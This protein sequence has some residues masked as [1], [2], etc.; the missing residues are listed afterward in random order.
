[1]T[2]KFE[3]LIQQLQLRLARATTSMLRLRNEALREHL[4]L[5][6]EQ[7]F[8]STDSLTGDAVFEST[9]GW[10]EQS[11]TMQQL[12]GSLLHPAVVAAMDDASCNEQRFPRTRTPYAHQLEAW[13]TLCGK[14][15][16][17]VVVKSGTGSG[18]TECFLVPVLDDLMREADAA[19]RLTGVR[20]LFLYPL[21]A[22][23]NSQ[24]ERLEAWCNPLEGKVRFALYNGNTPQSVKKAERDSHVAE[25]VD[26][27]TLREDPPPIVVTNSTMLEYV[28]VRREDAP[29]RDA[30][31]GKLRWIVIDEAHSYVGSAA[32]E[33]ALLLRRVAH[34][35]DVGPEDI[36]YVATSATIGGAESDGALR[37]FL[38]EVAGVPEDRVVVVTG[39][40]TKPS[41]VAPKAP[42]TADI[43]ALQEADPATIAAAVSQDPAITA[44]RAALSTHRTSG[45][46]LDSLVRIYTGQASKSAND[47]ARTLR[48]LDIASE[49]EVVRP[50]GTTEPFLP[51]RGHLFARPLVGVWACWNPKCPERPSEAGQSWPFGRI[52]LEHRTNCG[53]CK[54]QASEV[55]SCSECGEVYLSAVEDHDKG[56]R[57]RGHYV[58]EDD[59][60]DLDLEPV[61]D[62]S[63][64]TEE[65]DDKSSAGKSES[66]YLLTTRPVDPYALKA[67]LALPIR[68]SAGDG[69]FAPDNGG[70]I[71]LVRSLD[72]HQ[73][74]NQK[75]RF[76]CILCL[77][78][79]TT[80]R[81]MLRGLRSG[82]PFSLSVA[83]P[84]LLEACPPMEGKQRNAPSDG[85]RLITFTDS[86]QGTARFAARSQAE[87]E[88]NYVR[89]KLL[90]HLVEARIKAGPDA[91]ELEV[92]R[93][94][95]DRLAGKLGAGDEDV[96]ELD[97]EI[98]EKSR[99][100]PGRLTW[101]EL[102]DR[103][104]ADRE[105]SH[106]V[107]R[108]WE[109]ISLGN[110]SKDRVP[111]ILLFREFM[112]R[113][114][115]MTSL[116][117]LGFARI[118]YPWI[119]ACDA[120]SEWPRSASKEDWQDLVKL[121]IDYLFRS[122][123]A[124]V[125][126]QDCVRWLGTKIRLRS[127]QGPDAS[128]N[129]STD[130]I[131]WPSVKKSG[132]SNLPRF[133]KLMARGLGLSLDK[134]EDVHTVNVLLHRLWTT[135][136]P[137][138]TAD[139]AEEYRYDFATKGNFELESVH[140]A[141]LCPITR[142]VLDTTFRGLTPYMPRV[143]APDEFCKATKFRM[144]QVP[145]AFWDAVE[146]GKWSSRAVND[147]LESDADVLE[148]RR[149]GA[150]V[151]ASD[152]IAATTDYFRVGEHSAQQGSSRL[153][154]LEK[155]FKGGWL[156]VLSCSTT[157][158]M[159]VDIGGLSTVAMNN[160]PP[161]PANYLQRAGRAGR[162]KEKRAAAFTLCS[163]SPHGASVFRSPE[164][165]FTTVIEPPKLALDSVP[166]AERHV[167]ALLLSEFLA[168]TT[169]NATGKTC[170]WFFEPDT[171]GAAQC[172]RFADWCR[173]VTA[174]QHPRVARGLARLVVGTSLEGRDTTALALR[175]V[176]NL[177]AV[178]A[179]WR[180]E[181][182]S[183]LAQ[184]KSVAKAKPS[185]EDDVQVPDSQGRRKPKGNPAEVAIHH[186]LE[187]I[188]GEYL[189]REL[190]E[191]GFLPGYGFPT[192]LGEF[193]YTTA[194]D[195]SADEYRR[196]KQKADTEAA[197]EEGFDR[198]G[199]ARKREYPSRPLPLAIRDY[200]PG[201]RV[202]LDGRVYQ[203]HGIS[204][205]WHVPA[206]EASVQELQELR[207][208]VHCKQC[209]T[210]RTE[211][212]KPESCSNCGSTTIRAHQYL[213]PAGFATDIR[214][215]PDNDI[216]NVHY[217]PVSDPWVSVPD[218]EWASLDNPGLGAHRSSRHGI[219]FHF[220]AGSA[221]FG[222]AICL[223]CGR[224]AEETEEKEKALPKA[225]IDHRPLRG[226][227]ED[228]T[229]C[230]ANDEQWAFQ[231]NIWLGVSSQTDVYEVSWNDPRT[232]QPWTDEAGLETLA[233]AMREGLANVLGIE[234]REL[235]VVVHDL[236]RPGGNEERP[237]IAIY[238]TAP[239]GAGYASI[240]G[241]RLREVLANAKSVLECKER[242]AS[243]CHACVLTYDTQG[244]ADRLNRHAALEFLQLVEAGGYSMPPEHQFFGNG[245]TAEV[246]PLRHVLQ[247]ATK[248]HSPELVRIHLTGDAKKWDL[249]REAWRMAA[250]LTTLAAAGCRVEL[251][252]T[253]RALT[254][255]DAAV[256]SRLASNC[257]SSGW[258][259]FAVAESVRAGKGFLLAELVVD[260]RL[261]QWAT[262]SEATGAPGPEW[263]SAR[264][265]SVLVRGESSGKAATAGRLVSVAELRPAP[266][267]GLRDAGIRTELD[268]SVQEFGSK[269]WNHMIRVS[270]EL[271]SRLQ[272]ANSPLVTVRYTDRYLRSPL[273]VRLLHCVLRR[274][275]ELTPRSGAAT[276]PRAEV[277]TTYP[278]RMRERI[279]Q[280]V[281]EDDWDESD[282]QRNLIE[283]MLRDAGFEPKLTRQA[284]SQ[285]PHAR[286]LELTWQDGAR[287]VIALD[288]GMGAWKT[289][290]D[291]SYAF[292]DDLARQASRM[293]GAKFDVCNRSTH[294][295][296]V[297]VHLASPP[298][299]K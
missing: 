244:R 57:L 94:K 213:E 141:W 42:R 75:A 252:V 260:N 121:S 222:Y 294:T 219:V 24:R 18:K 203:S 280:A 115:R 4:R 28:L 199:P 97:R 230:K 239:G 258:Q 212:H 33:L 90:H 72:G 29:I 267:P 1:M 80:R 147:W 91:K 266:R 221:R 277:L 240:A 30:S 111:G 11:L 106:W 96:R 264:A 247:R 246:S 133:V 19:G 298:T 206:S 179:K 241:S 205:H 184:Q 43:D 187:R 256:R 3:P 149:I 53:T 228:G 20:A 44:V 265:Q 112:R 34:A 117:T 137:H 275:A 161:H 165:P 176:G 245:S 250:E 220:Q 223:R 156:N 214:E 145:H 170:T 278:S 131:K 36:R 297:Y 215:E 105:I 270:P 195:L 55:L 135:V 174:A 153:Q 41:Q 290:S 50:D 138:L 10:E 263:G 268:C 226:R 95:R 32:A 167:H 202:V 257:E 173:D 108:D 40:R 87:S 269:F 271:V 171:T 194:Y 152:R 251:V 276:G 234:T 166:I 88:R 52:H 216:G 123:P 232:G 23:I 249:D 168:T 283:T 78:R 59:S 2:T 227:N 209:G 26:R 178:V 279:S 98:A 140:E 198:S 47:R 197:G 102:A 253:E 73:G 56:G 62:E 81:Q 128:A 119:D 143:D 65:L 236:R 157:M 45:M 218:A 287:F 122:Y 101:Q 64:D 288:Q 114:M 76:Q 7:P 224:A 155:D 116:E 208:A 210:A 54:S 124:L 191:R 235:G 261:S 83:I 289:T 110:V 25:V 255:L 38:A 201:A 248:A 188:R 229:R 259:V 31:G 172:D 21:N 243:C 150:W 273:P 99:P 182:D 285:I 48:M 93:N 14:E 69:V 225:L 136:R 79:E 237:T 132:Q 190:T 164:W 16:K 281:F 177:E 189:L 162:R 104:A 85:R 142:R 17:S 22:L 238:D 175:T 100:Q 233:I 13:R 148:A 183:L 196:A 107:A 292:R 274:L 58:A 82:T 60:D 113:P 126:H 254:T 120:P 242:C 67:G 134:D 293:A 282:H 163:S 193:V 86:R 154:E 139:R 151:E 207:V 37:S 262:Q 66:E 89:S 63:T 61:E 51:L 130:T 272:D 15:R 9:F 49:A 68:L 295:I 118:R 71:G 169:G 299:D 231:R 284:P 74:G 109:G 146:G 70:S 125:Q 129:F 186:R 144:P 160:A 77:R 39:K 84:T 27:K 204:L 211:A 296:R 291:V 158:E 192:H 217:V 12:S 180:R 200:A 103:L 181:L 185:S 127:F 46:S 5:R 286:T 92:L 159:G 6:L 8:G 35:F